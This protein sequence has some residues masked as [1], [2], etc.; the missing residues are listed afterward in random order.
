MNRSPDWM[1]RPDR[2]WHNIGRRRLPSCA[3]SCSTNWKPWRTPT[4]CSPLPKGPSATHVSARDPPGRKPA[5]PSAAHEIRTYF[6]FVPHLH[7]RPG[8]ARQLLAAPRGHSCLRLGG[9]PAHSLAGESKNSSARA[10]AGR[11]VLCLD[12]AHHMATFPGSH[13]RPALAHRWTVGVSARTRR[14]QVLDMHADLRFRVRLDGCSDILR[15]CHL[16]YR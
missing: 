7:G 3:L 9:A 6:S 1:P 5:A 12:R 11:L 2:L 14:Q 8:R 10:C 13:T 4:H 16:S 15:V